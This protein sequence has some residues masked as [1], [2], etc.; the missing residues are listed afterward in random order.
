MK[1]RLSRFLLV[2]ALLAVVL[3]YFGVIKFQ[4]EIVLVA[5]EDLSF[6][7]GLDATKVIFLL[8][9]GSSRIVARCE[10]KKTVIEPVVRLDDGRM[11]YVLSGR[12]RIESKPTSILSLPRYL[13]CPGY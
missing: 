5:I 4:R 7:D 11:A 2:G 6:Y 13:G 9:A 10:D 3:I 8:S 12:F 1:A